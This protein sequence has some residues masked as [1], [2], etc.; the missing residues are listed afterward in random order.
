MI[1]DLD[2]PFAAG[3]LT[4]AR[5]SG[6]NHHGQLGLSGS[7]SDFVGSDLAVHPFAV[8]LQ[9]LYTPALSLL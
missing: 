1:D 8:G 9:I 5:G 2:R 4:R 6:A 3:A 7:K